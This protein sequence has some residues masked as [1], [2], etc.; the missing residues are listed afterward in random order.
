MLQ[1][2]SNLRAFKGSD[3]TSHLEDLEDDIRI[4]EIWRSV[5]DP[6]LRKVMIVEHP[7]AA[8]TA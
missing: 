4:T 5:T 6:D 3:T 1:V 2:F 8:G 7:K